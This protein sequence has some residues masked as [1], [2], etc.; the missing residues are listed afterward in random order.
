VH[1]ILLVHIVAVVFIRVV[2]TRIPIAR[3]FLYNL[4]GVQKVAS[5]EMVH[6]VKAKPLVA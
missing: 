6:K 4:L 2:P 1:Q 5:N 3:L